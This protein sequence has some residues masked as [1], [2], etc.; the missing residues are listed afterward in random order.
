MGAWRVKY[1]GACSVCGT[2][3]REGE[4]AAYV[5][6]S[7]RMYCLTCAPGQE[8]PA[9]PPLSRGVPGASTWR[10]HDRRL[11][12]DEARLAE[13]YGQRVGGF[14]ATVREE[15]QS[16]R[17]FA[18]GAY[19]EE[20]LAAA[21]A[22]VPGIEV[23]HD[24]RIPGSKGNIDHI[25]VAP[26]GIFV[27]DTKRYQ[28]RVELKR[29]GSIFYP[30]YRLYATGRD[31]TMEIAEIKALAKIV[32]DAILQHRVEPQPIAV[33]VLCFVDAERVRLGPKAHD[34]VLLETD[35]TIRELLLSE[36]EMAPGQIDHVARELG[37]LFPPK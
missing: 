2:W 32:D 29:K 11:A 33:P 14:I 18:S 20:K 22:K 26:A 28:G 10:E 7:R 23:L 1:D 24:R 15:R 8:A 13:R 30:E 4:E 6:A 21:L 9:T 3:L 25:V 36:V 27:I 31:R 16:T 19:G 37:R 17:S 12:N 35:Y 5:W 34:G